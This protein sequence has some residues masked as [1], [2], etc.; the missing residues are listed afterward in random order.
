ME[1]NLNYSKQKLVQVV[2]ARLKKLKKS[3]SLDDLQRANEFIQVTRSMAEHLQFISNLGKTAN[4]YACDMEQ[5]DED[6]GLM[7]VVD[8]IAEGC[9]LLTAL[10]SIKDLKKI[11]EGNLQWISEETNKYLE[12]ARIV[13]GSRIPIPPNIVDEQYIE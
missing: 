7:N 11:E 9:F 10:N 2:N 4:E 3:S 5:C 6:I 12:E 8:F 13:F 1:Q